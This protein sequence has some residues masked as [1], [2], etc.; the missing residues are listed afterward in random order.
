MALD[1]K[2]IK[3]ELPDKEAA[4]YEINS[5]RRI[6]G[7]LCKKPIGFFAFFIPEKNNKK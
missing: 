3:E 6:K 2:T 5:S 7:L 1:T 4:L